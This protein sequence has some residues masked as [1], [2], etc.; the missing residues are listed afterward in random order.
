MGVE[1]YDG[2]RIEEAVVVSTNMHRCEVVE[3]ASK[4]EANAELNSAAEV[5]MK[6]IADMEAKRVSCAESADEARISAES[7][8]ESA[9]SVQKNTEENKHDLT[10]IRQTGLHIETLLQYRGRVSYNN[11]YQYISLLK[12]SIYNCRPRKPHM[13][14][15]LY[16]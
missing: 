12:T 6:Y 2:D 13:C 7:A 5:W 3:G 10:K 9:T 15:H 14:F 11:N 1:T 8:K 16:I 4:K